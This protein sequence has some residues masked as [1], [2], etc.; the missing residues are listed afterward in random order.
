MWLISSPETATICYGRVTGDSPIRS[1]AKLNLEAICAGPAGCSLPS[2][3][4]LATRAGSCHD[5]ALS[6]EGQ[7]A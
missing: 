3:A 6:M 7:Y 1:E 4:G 5:M 2:R